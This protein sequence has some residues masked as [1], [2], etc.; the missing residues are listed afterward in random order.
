MPSRNSRCSPAEP[1]RSRVHALTDA[2][3]AHRRKSGAGGLQTMR[4]SKPTTLA[5]AAAR[6]DR[7]RRSGGPMYHPGPSMGDIR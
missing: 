4:H 7:P 5:G 2:F 6:S 1:A 3:P